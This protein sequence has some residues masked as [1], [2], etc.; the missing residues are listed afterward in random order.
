MR[1]HASG[2]PFSDPSGDRLRSWLGIGPDTFYDESRIAIVPMGFCF[3]GYDKAGGDLPPRRECA[4]LWRN[5]VLATLPN[6]RLMVLVGSYAIRWHV[7]A[8]ARRSMTDTVADWAAIA[9]LGE[10]HAPTMLPLPHPSW[11]NTSW[12]KKNPWF[13]AEVLPVLRSRVA[14]SLRERD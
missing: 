9:A 14:Q 3:P 8:Y 5:Q 7:P 13:E 4:P 12:L 11:R 10:S 1:A 2:V 6:V